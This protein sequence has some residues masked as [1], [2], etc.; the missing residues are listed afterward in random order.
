[1]TQTATKPATT[2]TCPRCAGTGEKFHGMC[3]RCS[4]T[5]TVELAN[6]TPRIDSAI[7]ERRY[8][9]ILALRERAME[10]DGGPNGTLALESA[11][12]RDLLE[13]CEPE[14]HTRALTSIEQGRTDEVIHVLVAYYHGCVD[15]FSF[16]T[17]V[18]WTFT[19]DDEDGD[20]KSYTMN[21][22][23]DTYYGMLNGEATWIVNRNGLIHYVPASQMY[24]V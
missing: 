20:P 6:R 19:A 3:F 4:G 2:R 16:G 15:R 24:Q 8:R 22:T 21:G 7:G 11:W 5:G 17:L 10:L 18:A 9:L 12:G 13:S 14:R 1:M 23:V